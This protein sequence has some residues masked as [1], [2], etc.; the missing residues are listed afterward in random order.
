MN[1][2]HSVL[3]VNLNPEQYEA[4][5]HTNGS[6]LVV[7]G[8]GS[9]KTRVITTRIARL[10][11]EEQVSP[12]AIVA[13]TFTNKAAKEMK[14][15][16]RH[17]LGPE[18]VLP[19]I[20]TFHSYCLYILRRNP[21]IAPFD[22]FSILD[23]D[24]QTSLIKK[25]LKKHGLEK[26]LSHGEVQHQISQVKNKLQHKSNHAF[27][28]TLMQEI[29]AEYEQEKKHAHSLDFDDL[30]ITVYELLAHN[31]SFRS[32][33][34]SYTRHVLVD[35]Y[36][37]TNVVQH[38]L[39]KLM[40]SSPDTNLAIDSICAVGD[41]DQSIYSWRG[42]NVQNMLT[43]QSDFSPVSVIKIEQN[44]RSV[45]PILD[46][47][48]EVIA[49]NNIRNP[50]ALWSTR[51]AKNRL[52]SLSARSEYQEADALVACVQSLPKTKH[53]D[54]AI[55][56]RTHFQSR[57]IEE[58][59][60]NNGIP[61]KIVGGIT[62]YARKEIKDLL[63]YLRLILNPYDRVSLLRVLN[64]P[65]RGLGEKFQ[66]ALSEHWNTHPLF[67]FSM[68]L[69]D[70]Q[71]ENIGGCSG[72]KALAVQSFLGIFRGLAST[73]SCSDIVTTLLERTHYISY[74]QTN[75]DPQEARAKVENVQEFLRS[76]EHFEK[77]PREPG[78]DPA[79]LEG[80]LH[81]IALLQE[82][83]EAQEKDT[84]MVQMMTLHAAK[85]L[86]FDTVM[87]VGL[88]EGIFPSNRSLYA[89]ESLEEERRLFYV[90]M[91]RAKEHLILSR[92]YFRNQFG[93][94]SEQKI[95]RFLSEV[96]SGLLTHID[97]SDQSVAYLKPQVRS[98]FNGTEISLSQTPKA[99]K[100]FAGI[101]FKPARPTKSPAQ[102]KQASS[103]D[104]PWRKNR[105]VIHATFGPGLITKVEKRSDGTC[106]VTAKFKAGSKKV[107]SSFLKPV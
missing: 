22:S 33:F 31:S 36:Q 7:A 65:A 70:M 6:L 68:L 46:A 90:G 17:F 78:E 82:K 49:Q 32:Q 79:S 26:Q 100:M 14:E 2:S 42:A 103:N 39:L 66:Q 56:Y 48:N 4:V 28:T 73:M 3:G 107:L 85:G 38:Q 43:F 9:G 101:S 37:D 41:E 98:W 35:E 88:E 23:S 13:L 54:I 105:T 15:R 52:L 57:V 51:K 21:D 106:F 104:S 47:A 16:L 50:K 20:G 83:I 53:N 60:I 59:L 27:E 40:C 77:A 24:D 81:S 75:K 97:V 72:K 71:K 45:S 91:T 44:Y 61:Y 74:L 1:T 92:A 99:Q 67:D 29:F 8:A 63:A 18:S 84:P 89:D 12:H 76:V 5:K 30:L 11:L 25:I 58:M 19:Y 55:L 102:A 34:Q 69:S 87:L 95:S 93:T 80:F 62:F 10:M 94:I 64:T 86:E 96:P